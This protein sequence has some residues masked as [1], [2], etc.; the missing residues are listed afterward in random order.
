[1][2]GDRHVRFLGGGGA[3]M[4]RCY[5]TPWYGQGDR[6]DRPPAHLNAAPN[7]AHAFTEATSMQPSQAHGRASLKVPADAP[8]SARTKAR[9]G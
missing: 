7:A 8:A 5:P 9:A 2:P 1:M 3:A 6:Q 4:R